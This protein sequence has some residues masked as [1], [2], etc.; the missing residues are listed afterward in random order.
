M[1]PALWNETITLE[2]MIEHHLFDRKRAFWVEYWRS[3]S[4]N[5]MRLS[6]MVYA[7]VRY[8]F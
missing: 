8:D 6:E 5:S 7:H 3:R 2:H 4:Y 1:G